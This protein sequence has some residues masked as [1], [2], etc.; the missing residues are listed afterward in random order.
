MVFGTEEHYPADRTLNILNQEIPGSIA[1][2][3]IDNLAPIAISHPESMERLPVTIISGLLDDELDQ[4]KYPA[5]RAAWAQMPQKN[6][7]GFLRAYA[8]STLFHDASRIRF[9]TSFDR[10]IDQANRMVL[11]NSEAL[12]V[13]YD[14]DPD[15]YEDE[16]VQIFEPAHNVFGGQRPKEASDSAGVFQNSQY[17]STDRSW[18]F[19]RTSCDDCVNGSPWIKDWASTIPVS[20]NGGYVVEDIAKWLWQRFI[21]DGLRN[22]GPLERAHMVSLIGSRRDFPLLLAI[23]DGRLAIGKTVTLQDLDD[24]YNTPLDPT[25]L[26]YPYTTDD[27]LNTTYVTALVDELAARTIEL[28]ASNAD[29]RRSANGRVGQAINFLI[30]LPFHF[31][32]EGL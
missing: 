11:N 25:L 15:G 22:Y 28:N 13:S 27:V 8:I 7:L 10:H 26:E 4:E 18:T 29:D 12:R 9:A 24:D 17:T 1:S 5:I 6:L 21:N 2:E 23:R 32:Q 20:S 31:V 3:R 30:S 16:D 19:N 14:Y